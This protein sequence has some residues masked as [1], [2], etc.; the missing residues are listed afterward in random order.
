MP[1]TSEQHKKIKA[2]IRRYERSL[3]K[4]QAEHGSIYDGYGKRYLL[5]PLYLQIGDLSG[6]LQSFRWFEQT[7]A[8][9]IGEPSQYL[10]W[11]L[12]LYKVDNLDLARRKLVQ[13][14]L[15]NLYLVPH[16]LGMKQ[17]ELDIWH[18]SNIERPDYLEYLPGEYLELWDDDA[19]TWAESVY[20][21]PEVQEMLRE[22]VDIRERM[23]DEPPGPRRRQL[24]EDERRI[25]SSLEVDVE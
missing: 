18:A 3:R 25:G 5:G 4:E 23:K 14:M 15:R 1:D 10:C 6:T 9:D 21:D 20:Q 17:P 16:L 22:Y 19:R 24:I 8:D 7:F 11:A 13:T 2:R 12:A